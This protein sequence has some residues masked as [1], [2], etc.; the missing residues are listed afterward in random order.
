[1]RII[2][3]NENNCPNVSGRVSCCYHEHLQGRR[4]VIND[5]AKRM[6]VCTLADTDNTKFSA[7]VFIVNKKL[8][9]LQILDNL[10]YVMGLMALEVELQCWKSS[11][12]LWG[13]NSSPLRRGYWCCAASRV[14]G[15]DQFDPNLTECFFT[16][17]ELGWQ[18]LTLFFFKNRGQL[19][20]FKSSTTK[21][22]SSRNENQRGAMRHGSLVFVLNQSRVRYSSLRK[23]DGWHHSRIFKAYGNVP[24]VTPLGNFQS[25]RKIP[26]MTSISEFR[27]LT[28]K[29]HVWHHPRISPSVQTENISLVSTDLFL[30]SHCLLLWLCFWRVGLWHVPI[31][32]QDL[33]HATRRMLGLAQMRDKGQHSFLR[34]NILLHSG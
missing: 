6:I 12:K 20:W 10:N 2:K 7:A 26:L 21:T 11:E 18:C 1:M 27:N 17:A 3:N 23:S 9:I 13:P 5:A 14:L 16:L 30:G 19:L 32:N 8:T 24:W 29:F 25:S 15:I 34:I 33:N 22:K 31:G 28:G 4:M